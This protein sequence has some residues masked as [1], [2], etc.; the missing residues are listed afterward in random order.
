MGVDFRLDQFVPMI[1]TW[2]NAD[3]SGVI[4]AEFDS[5]LAAAQAGGE[6][7]ISLL[8]RDLNPPLLRFLTA[9]A[10]AVGEDLAQET[11]LAAAP[12]LPA[13]SGDERAFRAWLFTIARRRLVQ[14]WRDAGRRRS[15]AVDP[16]DF[17]LV[18]ASG[19][20][21]EGLEARDAAAELVAGL[22]AEQAEV[23][24]LRVV[25][26]FDPDE[27]SRIV[28]KSAGAVRVIQHRALRRLAR[29][30]SGEGVTR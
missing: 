13:F 28:G 20:D 4:G 19:D 29:T 30:F 18:P 17:A 10:H 11:W 2:G 26:G 7:A 15:S 8:Y 21:M 12:Q 27:V 14:H 5:V 23:V 9:Q 16:A 24:L 6:W 1:L 25:A 22:S 3:W